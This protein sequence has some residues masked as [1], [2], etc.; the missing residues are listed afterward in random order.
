MKDPDAAN[1][2]RIPIIKGWA[3]VGADGKLPP[4]GNTVD[5]DHRDPDQRDGKRGGD[6]ELDRHWIKR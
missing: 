3:D 6:W 1:L 2:D 5:P 4:V